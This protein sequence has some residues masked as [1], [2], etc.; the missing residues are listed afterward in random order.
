MKNLKLTEF[1]SLTASSEPVPG[2]GS[3][4]AVSGALGAALSEMVAN[5]TI[6]KKK[7]IDV[8]ENMKE[9]AAKASE[10]RERLLDDIQRDSNS[11]NDVMIA[12]KLPKDTDEQKKIR[13]EKM[14]SGLKIAA[15][16]PYEIA[17]DAFE[18][19]PLAE[20]VVSKGNTSAVT[21]GLVSAMM[22][23]TA[24][25][26]ALLNTKIN[27]ASIKDEA[28]VSEMSKKVKDLEDKV[29]LYEEKILSKSP[30]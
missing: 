15:T 30:Y 21:D 27:L 5:L 18:I 20:T 19:M 24:V 29:K 28:F 13:T 10:L 22:S 9:V 12:M 25:L 1:A 26:S 6:G 11:F 17:C 7:Y 4:A 2:G 23:R 8:E 14:Q 16:V 3:I